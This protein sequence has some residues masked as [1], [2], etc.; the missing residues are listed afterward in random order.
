[1]N[2]GVLPDMCLGEPTDMRV[3]LEHFGRCGCAFLYRYYVHTAFCEGR[4]EMNSIRRM[5][6]LMDTIMQ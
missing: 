2:H 6:E 1:V 5:H 3:V 4:E